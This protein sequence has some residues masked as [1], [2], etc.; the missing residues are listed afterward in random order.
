[1]ARG[2]GGGR[3]FSDVKCRGEESDGT[4]VGVARASSSVVVRWTNAN[5]FVVIAA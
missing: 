1:M 5:G 2:G 4:A 3:D